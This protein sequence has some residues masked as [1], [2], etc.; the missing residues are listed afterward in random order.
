MNRRRL[1]EGLSF[2]M[3]AGKLSGTSS[4]YGQTEEPQ[5]QPARK[6]SA[7]DRIQVGFI[8]PGSRGQELIRQ[9][10]RTP[11]VDIAAQCDVYEPRF[12]EVNELVGKNVPAHKDY[13]ELLD[14]KDL[15]VIYIATP[16][17]FHASYSIA[18][19]KG[20][21]PVY[22][23]KTIGFTT[24]DCANVVDTARKTGQIYQVGHQMRYASWIVESVNRV[25]KGDIGEPTHVYGY[26]HRSDNWRRE[27]PNPS[28]EHLMN[29]R[30][31][32]ESSGGLLEELGSHH[33]DIANWV[34]GEQPQTLLGSSSIA[35][36]H[37][38]R[39]VG[40]NVQ[41][42]LG[43]TK[44]HRMFFSSITDNGLMADQVWVY[45]TEGSLQITL[46][47]ATFYKRTSKMITEASHPDVVQKGVETGASYNANPELPY[48][49]PGY[50][51]GMKHGEDATLNACKSFM[52]CVRKKK[53]PFANVDVGFRSAIP[54]AIGRD[55]MYAGREAKVPQL[56]A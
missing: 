12:A 34:F 23:E 4:L 41:A 3:L 39:T 32:R 38:G 45:G 21:R 6:L 36:Y 19:M 17:V 47:D 35:V 52:E 53:Q 46:A 10:L 54:C 44:G 22:C 28:L 27:V 8:G 31:Y 30:L 25:H 15:D 9:L 56:T 33:I 14:R 43:Y 18:A 2:S 29:W 20:G 16:P 42:V 49:G 1:L 48:R 40:D 26:W 13:R 24:E 5:P 7:N 11:G 50:R 51:V 37:D 55:V